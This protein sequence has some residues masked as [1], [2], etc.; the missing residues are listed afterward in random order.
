MS[1]LHHYN[2]DHNTTSALEIIPYIL[3]MLP[4]KPGSVLDVGCGIG[5]W[6]RVFKDHNIDSVLGMDG[7]HVPTDQIMVDPNSE[8]KRCDLRNVGDF[9]SDQKFDLAISLEVAEHLPPDCAEDF[10]D[11]LTSSSDIIVFS[12]AIIGQTGENHLNEQ[13]PQYWKS[14]FEKRGFEMLDAFRSK[15][16]N[17]S[18]VN[19]WYRQNM[20]LIVR[21]DKRDLFP[22]GTFEN[23]YIHPELF[24]YKEQNRSRSLYKKIK[25]RVKG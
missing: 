12:A 7:D 16:W 20:F 21:K 23:F 3:E 11:F 14:L 22:F 19:W 15:F 10:I 1:V 13:D 17:N 24:H 8:F 9:K 25:D 6:L 18:K 5:Q 2:S 4:E